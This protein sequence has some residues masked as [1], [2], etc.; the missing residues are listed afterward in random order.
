MPNSQRQ[1]NFNRDE[2]RTPEDP[3][4]VLDEQLRSAHR[5]RRVEVCAMT[6]DLTSPPG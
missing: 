6:P 3:A 1:R 2:R 5:L 4:H